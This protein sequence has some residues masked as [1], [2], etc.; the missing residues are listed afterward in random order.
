MIPDSHHPFDSLLD[1]TIFVRDNKGFA[2]EIFSRMPLLS[3]SHYFYD[4][5][6]IAKL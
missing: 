4:M 3:D 1:P 5:C 2:K 6:R